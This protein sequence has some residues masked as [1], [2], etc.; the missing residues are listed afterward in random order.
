METPASSIESLIGKIESYGNT[1]YEL[2]KFKS[3][4]NANRIASILLSR[5]FVFINILLFLFFVN[6]GI[7]LLLGQLLG[8]IYYGFFI[9]AVAHLLI[10][11]IFY[12]F[13]NKWIRTPVSNFIITQ[14]LQ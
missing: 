13:L 10:S 11:L 1:R 4:E 2:S 9:V 12:F 3:L 7:A 5:I 6:V 8:K 14:L